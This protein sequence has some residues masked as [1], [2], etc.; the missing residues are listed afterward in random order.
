MGALGVA[1]ARR[2]ALQVAAPIETEP[3]MVAGEAVLCAERIVP[4]SDRHQKSRT[5]TTQ[6]ITKAN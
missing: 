5:A 4:T 6:R 1:G 2:A 3:G